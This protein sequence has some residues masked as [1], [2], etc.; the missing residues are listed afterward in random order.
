MVKQELPDIVISDIMMPKKDGFELTK[1]IN[2]SSELCHIPVVLLTA[3]TETSSQIEGM[4]S[5]ADLYVA[6]PFNIDFL[7][8]AID[9]QLKNRKRLQDIFLNGQMPRLDSSDINQLDVQF[10]T[11]MN[12]FLEKELA[13]PD[14]DILLLAQ[15]M[16]LSRSAFYRKFMNLT[17]LSP[18]AYIKKY[19]I[20]KS[21]EFMNSGKY[22]LTEI[23]EMTG[24]G[25]PSYFST[26]FKLEKGISPREFLNKLKENIPPKL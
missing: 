13:N 2:E 6:K 21:V 3:K 1:A 15:N 19:R 23:G 5:G 4:N 9:A 16:N 24:F 14:L 10:L 26:A 20:N 17:K 11:K 7:L 8:A 12:V 25:S 18:I 22:T